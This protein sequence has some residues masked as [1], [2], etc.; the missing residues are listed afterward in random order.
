MREE[1]GVQVRLGVV[2]IVAVARE[3]AQEHALVALVP[4]VDGQDDELLV[5]GPGVGQGGHEGAVNHVPELSVVL[6]F[7]L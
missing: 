2:V 3:S 7:L 1:Y 6:A 5:D 4:V